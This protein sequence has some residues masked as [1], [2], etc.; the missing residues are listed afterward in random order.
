M[1]FIKIIGVCLVEA[2]SSRNTAAVGPA[3]SNG[4]RDY[5]L[6]Q[7]NNKYWCSNGVAGKDCNVK[8]EGILNI[9]IS[10]LNYF[11]TC[12]AKFTENSCLM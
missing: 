2:E 1:Y 8:C 12:D 9:F 11:D 7:I 5:G 6:F 3:N 4:S 10:T